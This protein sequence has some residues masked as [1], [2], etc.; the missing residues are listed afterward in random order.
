MRGFQGILASTL[1]VVGLTGCGRKPACPNC[2]TVVVAATGEPTSIFPPLAFETVGRDIGD[3]VYERLAD[4]QPGR[5]TIDEAAYTPAMAASWER[6]DSVT[7][8]F[9][10]RPGAHW[11]DG[12]PVTPADVQYSFD[13]FADSVIDA[14]A[15]ASLVA[16]ISSVTIADSSAV[17]VHFTHAYSEQLF[18]ATYH[19]RI[20]PRHI[21]E[22]AGPRAQWGEDTT[23]ARLVGSGPYRVESWQRGQSLVLRADS[24]VSPLPDIRRLIWRFTDDPEAAANLLLSHEGDLLETAALAG[25]D[26]LATDS[27]YRLIPFPSANYGLLEFRISGAKS[28]ASDAILGNRDVRRALVSAVDRTAIARGLFGPEAKVPPGPISQLLWIWSRDI[29]TQSYDTVAATRALDGAGWIRGKSGMRSRGGRPLRLDIL[30]PNTSSVRRRAAEAVQAAWRLIGV[31]ASVSLVD[32]PVMQQRIARGDFDTFVGAWQDEPSPR[33]LAEQW[34]RGGWD[35]LNYGHYANPILDSLLVAAGRTSSASEATRI[36]HE[37]LDTINADA[38]A[39]FLFAPT[40]IAAVSR[41]L[42]P[43]TI[44]PYSWLSGLPGWKLKEEK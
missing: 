9:T 25:A 17:L 12:R 19:V 35:D 13:V 5:P 40:N 16:N 18:D 36:Y 28:R 14:I 3:M 21:W 33:G 23:L 43:G 37:V 32:F 31:D 39:M 44:N 10:L 22:G 4:L 15:R 27:A 2:G 29:Q 26:R 7:W 30:V 6:V 34:S 42:M 11:Q 41:R 38:P 8:R 20:L 24:T 1:L